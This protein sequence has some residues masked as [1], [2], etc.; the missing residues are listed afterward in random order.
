EVVDLERM[1]QHVTSVK[2]EQGSY[3]ADIV[4]IATGAWS[5]KFTK[6]LDYKLP[7]TAGKG[8]SVTISNPNLHLKHPLY[9]GDSKG[10]ITPF[11]N[12]LRMGGT[13]ELS[14][15]NLNFDKKR[16]QGIRSSAAPYLKETIAGDHEE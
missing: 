9:L 13:M 7:L 8:Y 12:A 6:S 5:D 1:D 4:V 16:M 2:T 10:G 3:E 14:G 11:D 15:F